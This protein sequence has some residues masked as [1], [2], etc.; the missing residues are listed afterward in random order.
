M[1]LT[2]TLYSRLGIPHLAYVHCEL[3]LDCYENSCPIDE[4]IRAIG[5][6]AFIM[7][8]SGHY[9]K[10]ISALESINT[11]IHES[12][13]FHQYLILCIGLIKFRRAVR[14]YTSPS[15]YVLYPILTKAYTR[16]V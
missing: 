16:Q 4:R 1:L 11:S 6:R 12:L 9:D 7:S 10:A 2:S 3:L 14:G 15:Y 5:R 13:K 8:Q